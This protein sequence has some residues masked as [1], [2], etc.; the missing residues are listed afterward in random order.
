MSDI[1]KINK[2]IKGAGKGKIDFITEM[3]EALGLDK[4]KKKKQNKK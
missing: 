2:V 1:E 3:S 4:I